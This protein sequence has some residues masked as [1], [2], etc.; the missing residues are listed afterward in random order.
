LIRAVNDRWPRQAAPD[1][2]NGA[3]DAV[4]MPCTSVLV[5]DRRALKLEAPPA[6]AVVAPLD[7]LPSA[8]PAGW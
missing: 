5:L 3:A 2:A 4:R 1:R 8:P 7:W 6:C